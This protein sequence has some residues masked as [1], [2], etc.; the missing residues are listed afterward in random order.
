MIQFKSFQTEKST[1]NPH[2]RNKST[3]YLAEGTD[4]YLMC[5]QNQVLSLHVLYILRHH[6]NA[7]KCKYLFFSFY[8]GR[9]WDAGLSNQVSKFSHG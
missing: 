4:F 8:K 6:Q 2:H 5:T 9:N 3:I 1:Q 7:I